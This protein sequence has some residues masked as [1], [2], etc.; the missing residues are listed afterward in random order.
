MMMNGHDDKDFDENL[1][2]DAWL[3]E[4]YPDYD[5]GLDPL[6]PVGGNVCSSNLP[7]K[8]PVAKKPRWQL[9]L[10][11][12]YKPTDKAKKMQEEID[13]LRVERICKR[14][15]DAKKVS[16]KTISQSYE[17]EVSVQG[18]SLGRVKDDG[19]G[20]WKMYPGFKWGDTYARRVI[21]DDN[22]TSFL[23]SGRALVDLW[24]IS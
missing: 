22:Y 21:V 10:D 9:P 8:L 17:Y 16:W 24:I 13:K 20:K 18:V 7:A 19:N 12:E 14:T 23:D 3:E 1:D 6:L 4:E 5:H 2:W 11:W 15:E